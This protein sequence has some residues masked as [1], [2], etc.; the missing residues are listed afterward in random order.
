MLYKVDEQR[1][2]STTVAR[3]MCG[4]SQSVPG[5]EDV[6][7][8]A[9]L[10]DRRVGEGM[11]FNSPAGI[12]Q[13]ALAV[14]TIQNRTLMKLLANR[15]ISS[16]DTFV[17]ALRNQQILAGLRVMDLGSGIVPGFALAAKALGAEVHTVDALEIPPNVAAQL[18]SHTTGNLSRDDM[19]AI[20]QGAT[21]G[22]FTI[23][24]EALRPPGPE[25]EELQYPRSHAIAQIGKAL[26]RP[27]G[28]LHQTS[29]QE[30]RQL[31]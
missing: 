3:R 25:Y 28:W 12:G 4:E 31:V 21:D 17:R 2:L 30:L 19:P 8:Q 29:T 11:F 6:F 20:L 26:L 22:D 18:D 1:V 23:V 7:E 9:G 13:L 27:C 10:D 5:F 14:S 15:S 24:S 16:G